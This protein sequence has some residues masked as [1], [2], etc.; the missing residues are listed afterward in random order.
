[1]TEVEKNLNF[2]KRVF[3]LKSTDEEEMQEKTVTHYQVESL[4]TV[5]I[6]ARQWIGWPDHGTPLEEDVA[7]IEKFID[8]MHKER[9][10]YP[11]SPVVIHCR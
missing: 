11:N 7:V 3:S 1:M 4:Y 10:A 9:T 5:F 8:L 2:T 6:E